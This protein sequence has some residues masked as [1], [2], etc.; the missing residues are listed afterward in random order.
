MS[1][2]GSRRWR[3]FGGAA[4]AGLGLYSL[5]TLVSAPLVA[6]AGGCSKTSPVADVLVTQSASGTFSGST[7]LSV[8]FTVTAENEGPCAAN[9][10]TV[11]ANVADTSFPALTLT[12]ISTN[13]SSAVCTPAVGGTSGGGV[14]CVFA[15]VSAPSDANTKNP[16]TAVV[17]FSVTSTAGNLGGVGAPP[18]TS[19]ATA[20]SDASTTDSDPGNNTSHG[21][22]L[23]DGG[24]L[25][26][27]G[28]QSTA[29][30]VP[31]GVHGSAEIET[32]VKDPNPP[33]GSFGQ[34]VLINSDSFLDSS[35]NPTSPLQVVTFD[36]PIT[37]STPQ[38][39][40]KVTVW[41]ELDG[42]TTWVQVPNCT[43]SLNQPDPSPSCV[44]SVTKLKGGP[45]GSFFEIVVNTTVTSK[46]IN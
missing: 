30:S 42:T 37:N 43:N 33:K 12:V 14:S 46:W 32:G 35:G 5:V 2:S 13:P 34:I 41:H 25:Q 45:T 16:G 1:A 31:H 23:V 22:F 44:L 10:V 21:A 8:T 19:I 38:S 11:A 27:T 20:N 40:S 17:V 9:N 24:S 26:L 28:F 29:I 7:A 3:V 4:A 18:V 15:K 39:T 6:Q 36:V